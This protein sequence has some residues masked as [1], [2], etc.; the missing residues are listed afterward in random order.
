M[1]LQCPGRWRT[2]AIRGNPVHDSLQ[3]SGPGPNRLTE[4]APV[5]LL[6]MGAD[7]LAASRPATPVQMA[8][9]CLQLGFDSVIPASWGDELA[10]AALLDELSLRGARGEARPLLLV[11]C[12]HVAQRVLA[13]GEELRDQLLAVAPPPVALARY[14]RALAGDQAV[15]LTWAGECPAVEA[16]GLDA[17]LSAGQLLG[18]LQGAGIDP[19]RQPL[20]F[21]DVIPPDRRRHFSRPG[22]VPTKEAVEAVA[23]DWR[24]V[25]VVDQDLVTTLAGL[26]LRDDPVAVDVA[27]RV[28][29]A[30][31]GARGECGAEVRDAI[32]ALE[33]PRSS[34][35]VVDHSVEFD[36]TQSLP[37]AV[38]APPGARV[39]LRDRVIPPTE[40]PPAH[41]VPATRE[42]GSEPPPRP[43][44]SPGART[45]TGVTPTSR[46][47]EGRSLPR[48][49]VARRRTTPR[50]V[51][52]HQVPAE[53]R[54]YGGHSGPLGRLSRE[55]LT[56]VPERVD[57][58][59]APAPASASPAPLTAVQAGLLFAAVAL[60]GVVVGTIAGWLLKG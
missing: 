25:E 44:N 35:P 30:C 10:A 39:G 1:G 46:T 28:G 8:H 51:E 19:A 31:A 4:T 60:A 42:G 7:A 15:Q 32:E 33:P 12:P 47:P 22:G 5:R 59:P 53:P 34:A 26:L 38:V 37:A 41:P 6:L 17:H 49:Y 13:N 50:S 55:D 14:L 24:L 16:A 9:A 23:G 56:P 58:P 11:S 57:P 18:A 36:R 21:E 40:H 43:R 3:P 52:V 29:C 2:L 27:T 48:A 54:L 45:I 20:E